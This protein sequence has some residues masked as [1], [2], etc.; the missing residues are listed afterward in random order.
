MKLLELVLQEA[1]DQALDQFFQLLDKQWGSA[2]IISITAVGSGS[3]FRT[4][5]IAVVG[6]ALVTT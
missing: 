1:L 3:R 6:G 4:L 5:I 2:H